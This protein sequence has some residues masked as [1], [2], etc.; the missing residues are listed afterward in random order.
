[1]F[2]GS[3]KTKPIFILV[4][5]LTLS[6]FFKHKPDLFPGADGWDGDKGHLETSSAI[7]FWPH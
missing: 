3:Q 2:L 6:L 5:L 7:I 4:V 1:M